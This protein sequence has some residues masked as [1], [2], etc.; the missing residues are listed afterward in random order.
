MLTNGL[1]VDLQQKNMKIALIGYGKMGRA[2]EDIATKVGH[3]VVLTIDDPDFDAE[4]LKKADVAIE[5]TTPQS[6]VSNIKKCA[7]AGIP[8]VVGTTAWYND[9]NDACDYVLSKN[10]GLFTATNFS[11]GVN[12]FWRITEMAAKLI[13]DYDEYDAFIDEVHHTQKLDAPSGTA[14]T[15]AE[16]VLANF[17]RKNNWVH[18]EN[19]IGSST[20]ELEL[21]VRSFREENVPGTHTVSFKS[22]IDTIEI[23]HTAHSR[24]GF[25]S[26]AL[27]AAEF[28]TG[29]SGIYTMKDLLNE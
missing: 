26:G 7:D 11:I 23:T 14:I 13:N 24:K 12:L 22:D 8:I 4:T 29:K 27:R 20:N 21:S 6:A 19:G 1:V 2:I 17:G 5:F 15:T 16:K 18:H 25:A 3:Q 10:S 9:Y 28:M